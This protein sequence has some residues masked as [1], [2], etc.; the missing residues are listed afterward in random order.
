MRIIL[1]LLL[2]CFLLTGC[3]AN[4]IS[5]LPDA[6]VYIAK[7]IDNYFPS[8]S[9]YLPQKTLDNNVVNTNIVK[10]FH[11]PPQAFIQGGVRLQIAKVCQG[12]SITKNI[13]DDFF[14][15]PVDFKKKISINAWRGIFYSP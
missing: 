11:I 9:K 3:K 8:L 12:G 7:Q 13:C 5:S 4:I 2:S 15:T 10:K 6:F 1:I 14:M